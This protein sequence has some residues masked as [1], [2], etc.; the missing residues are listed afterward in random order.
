MNIEEKGRGIRYQKKTTPRIHYE[1]LWSP[2]EKCKEIVKNEWLD[3][4]K[5]SRENVGHIL[6]KRAKESLA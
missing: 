3:H 6:K 5:W 4:T 2:Y 1:D